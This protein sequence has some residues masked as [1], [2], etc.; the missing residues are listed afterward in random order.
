MVH[1][2]GSNLDLARCINGDMVLGLDTDLLE[3]T[4]DWEKKNGVCKEEE[5]KDSS[6]SYFL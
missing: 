6:P 5:R 3:R 1:R 4:V 2:N